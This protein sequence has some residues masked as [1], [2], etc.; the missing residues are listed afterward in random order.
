MDAADPLDFPERHHLFLHALKAR[1]AHEAMRQLHAILLEHPELTGKYCGALASLLYHQ[2][3]LETAARLYQDTVT[4]DPDD[5]TA[6]LHLGIVLWR[7]GQTTE[8]SRHWNY[9]A[10]RHP[11]TPHAHFQKALSDISNS[12]PKKARPALKRILASIDQSHPL[13]A[14]S[15]KVLALIDQPAISSQPPSPP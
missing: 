14:E 11:D 6:R 7:L 10:E 12:Q 15:T 9:I 5:L 1:N 8:A 3:D 13:W 2:G 4:F